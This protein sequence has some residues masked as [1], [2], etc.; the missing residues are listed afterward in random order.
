[1]S[2]TRRRTRTLL[3]IALLLTS[4][5]PTVW[6]DTPLTT[7]PNDGQMRISIDVCAQECNQSIHEALQTCR[8]MPAAPTDAT[9]QTTPGAPPTAQGEASTGSQTVSE[10]TCERD[11]DGEL[12]SLKETLESNCDTAVTGAVAEEQRASREAIAGV[13][14][15]RDTW[16]AAAEKADRDAGIWQV[17]GVVGVALGLVGLVVAVAS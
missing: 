5:L 12:S 6:S 1:M 2:L 7:P 13:T 10:T 16:K 9:G 15:E 4:T 8:A 3:P 17:V 14:A 11:C